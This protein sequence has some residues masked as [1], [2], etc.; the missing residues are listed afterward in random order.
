[1]IFVVYPFLMDNSFKQQISEYV[2]FNLRK[3]L[4]LDCG[5]ILDMAEIFKQNF[6]V[7]ISLENDGFVRGVSGNLKQEEP[8]QRA[9]LKETFGAAISDD[10]FPPLKPDELNSTKIFVTLVDKKDIM[11]SKVFEC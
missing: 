8:L 9:L 11:S 3:I 2:R 10:R 5:E 7:F 1:M 6:Y 4:H